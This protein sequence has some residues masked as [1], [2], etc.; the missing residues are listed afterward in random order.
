MEENNMTKVWF[1]IASPKSN[2][3]VWE[4]IENPHWQKYKG[5]TA[6]GIP[7]GNEDINK[8][9]HIEKGDVILC[10]DAAPKTAI[11]GQ[12]KCTECYDDDAKNPGFKNGVCISDYKKY[13]VPIKFSDLRKKGFGFIEDFLG[14]NNGRR[15]SIVEVPKNDW[16][17]FNKIYAKRRTIISYKSC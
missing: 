4:N 1:F 11:I 8:I 3:E 10:Y 17:N 16:D 12:C 6:W 15:R 9:E 7:D 2:Y 14:N 13:E 5:H